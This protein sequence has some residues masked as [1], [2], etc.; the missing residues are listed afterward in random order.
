MRWGDPPD[1]SKAKKAPD[2]LPAIL[3]GPGPGPGPGP[4]ARVAHAAATLKGQGCLDSQCQECACRLDPLMKQANRSA[5][6]IES[7][8]LR[9]LAPPIFFAST[10]R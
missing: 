9:H 8:W 7:H 10:R 4:S 3:S 1:D 5:T 2:E 6:H